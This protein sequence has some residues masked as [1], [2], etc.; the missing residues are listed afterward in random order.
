[1]TCKKIHFNLMDSFVV[2]TYNDEVVILFFLIIEISKI[3]F[4]LFL[5]FLNTF[6][7]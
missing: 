7:L 4:L 5:S 3:H 2:E 6:S 1:M